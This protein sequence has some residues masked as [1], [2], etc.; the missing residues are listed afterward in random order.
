MGEDV[1]L[2]YLRT[3][4]DFEQGNVAPETAF[5]LDR[6]LALLDEVGAPQLRL[7]VIHIAGTKGKG[8]TAAMIASIT[9]AGGYRTGLFTQPHLLRVQERFQMDGDSIDEEALDKIMLGVIRPAVERLRARGVANVQQFEAQVTLAFL[10]FEARQAEVVVLETGLG[11]RLDGTN[12]VLAPVC[13]TLTPIGYDHM[14]ILGN[15][16]EKIAGE[17]A[18]II[19][20]G[21]PV[22]T[23]PQGPEAAT[24]F[25]RAARERRSPLLRAGHEWEA[26]TAEL[27]LEGTTFHLI[28]DW[29]R[30]REVGVHVRPIWPSASETGGLTDLFTPLLGAHQAANAGTAAVT[31]ITAS[32]RLPGITPDAVRRGLATVSWPGR[33]QIIAEKPAVVLD[34]A[35]TAE[36]AHALSAT[37]D[38]LFG[39]KRLVL[40]L[41]MAADKDI[42]A[43]VAPLAARASAAVATRSDHPRAAPPEVVEAALWAA[44]APAVEQR[45]H[46]WDAVRR[47]RA[48]A[49][50]DGVVLVTGSLH[51]VGS[52]LGAWTAEQETP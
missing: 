40:V 8:S 7:P 9:R 48:L 13:V 23:A 25:E 1:G 33:L 52:V 38:A 51:V 21:V 22:V 45:D 30:L 3:F 4:P 42:P 12:V 5:T 46:P 14:A 44:G 36:S 39:G 24:V 15:T 31:A 50:E 29:A 6:V 41:G 35:H 26:R 18:A 28:M 49:G 16:L 37:M 47:A 34:G 19:K 17:K 27:S 20:T 32:H 10:W 2:R 11:G 43:T